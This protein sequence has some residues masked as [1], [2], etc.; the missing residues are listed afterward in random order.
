V[1]DSV[2]MYLFWRDKAQIVMDRDAVLE[3]YISAIKEHDIPIL[4]IEDGFSEE[5]FEGWQNLLEALGDRIFIIGDDLVT[6]N[7]KTIELAAAKRLINTV[8]IKANQIGTLYETILAILVS[9]GKDFE[10]VVS[11]RSKSPNDDMEAQIALAVNALGL[12]AGGGANTE[13]LVKYHA[14]TELMQS[15]LEDSANRGI[16]QGLRP[17]IS[18]VYAYE[19]PTNAG[20]PSVGS[21]VEFELA[22]Q[23]IHLKYKGATPLGTSAGTGE[24]IHLVDST[25]EISE[26]REVIQKHRDLFDDIEPGVVSFSKQVNEQQIREIGSPDLLN[27]FNRTQR[28]AGKGC[29]NA[30]DNVNM[31]I[32]PFLKGM[33][34]SALSL[35]QIDRMLL[36]L[37][38]RLARRRGKLDASASSEECVHV[39]QRK[40]NLG[41]NAILSVSLAMARGAAHLRGQNLYEILREEIIAIIA[42][43][44]NTYS[45]Q[46][47]GGQFADYVEALRGVNKI[48]TESGKSLYETLR[49][50]TQIYDELKIESDELNRQPAPLEVE[51]VQANRTEQGEQG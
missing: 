3:L 51:T 35:K 48:L 18:K 25:I 10:L 14:V 49:N 13:R 44:A 36:S 5:D 24:A 38:L 26:H 43:L 8:L 31:V 41:M 15:G 39:M 7:D 17:V 23:G 47:R 37:E 34:V 12:K 9:L 46:I 42:R 16:K 2:G 11:H 32:A 29:L 27:L 4:S 6:T 21:T 30:V 33:D 20:I 40:Q 45:V 19:E 22:E 50:D 28:Y 1:P